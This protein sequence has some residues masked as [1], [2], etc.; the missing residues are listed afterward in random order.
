MSSPG[1]YALHQL[2]E[3]IPVRLCF[4]IRVT[5]FPVHG[6]TLALWEGSVIKLRV[7][8]LLGKVVVNSCTI[9]MLFHLAFQGWEIVKGLAAID[10]HPARAI[11]ARDLRA[12]S[13]R[14]LEVC[15]AQLQHYHATLRLVT[16]PDGCQI[17]DAIQKEV[18]VTRALLVQCEK[19]FNAASR[20]TVIVC[21]QKSSKDAVKKSLLKGVAK[22]FVFTVAPALA[23]LFG[24][25]L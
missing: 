13:G 18:I 20:A 9:K 14:I 4:L 19:V 25:F 2:R 12:R 10:I 15:I 8:A 3:G 11:V 1:K 17:L 23:V 6:H 24:N 7:K 21:G 16:K 22:I 5:V